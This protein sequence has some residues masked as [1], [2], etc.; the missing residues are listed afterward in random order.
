MLKLSDNTNICL[1]FLFLGWLWGVNDNDRLAAIDVIGAHQVVLAVPISD[2]MDDFDRITA[3]QALP[4]AGRAVRPH[5]NDRRA[6]NML[7][8][9]A[10]Y[11]NLGAAAYYRTHSGA[12]A[13][14]WRPATHAE[15]NGQDRN[16]RFAHLI[17]ANALG[18]GGFY[19]H[20][21]VVISIRK[22]NAGELLLGP[23]PMD[24]FTY[25]TNIDNRTWVTR[26]NP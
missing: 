4:R 18:M 20:L 23:R 9:S 16:V 5:I 12:L 7:W 21:L 3:I 25:P 22:I 13:Y 17:N 6:E 15:R 1:F 19:T 14:L 11:A 24:R 2:V 8:H 26:Y 10:W